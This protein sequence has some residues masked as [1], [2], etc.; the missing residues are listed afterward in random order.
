MTKAIKETGEQIKDFISG[1][2]AKLCE[3]GPP[4]VGSKA[5][6]TIYSPNNFTR[7]LTRAFFYFKEGIMVKLF[8]YDKAVNAWVFVDWG[9][10]SKVTEY[11]QQ[12]YVVVYIYERTAIK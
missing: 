5:W 12:G 4:P 1:E 8:K 10:T 6:P 3:R 9:I 2:K 11:T 7:R